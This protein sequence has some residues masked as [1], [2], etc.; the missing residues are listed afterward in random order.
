MK[1]ITAAGKL[2]FPSLLWNVPV[3]E[4]I[5]YLTFDDGPVPEI[6]PWVLSLLKEYNA[7]VTFFCIGENVK[8]HPDI[9]HQVLAE[10][11]SIGNHT[12]NHLHGW[13]TSAD[14]YL[15]NILLAEKTIRE[16]LPL[17]PADTYPSEKPKTFPSEFHITQPTAHNLQ[18]GTDNQQPTTHNRQPTTDNSQLTT[19]NSFVHPLVRSLQNR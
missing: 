12:H 11:H 8:K 7:K 14:V 13:K 15:E 17:T 1:Y 19:E 10:G 6:T 5:L 9:F 4:K 18:P 16:N 3:T 2:F